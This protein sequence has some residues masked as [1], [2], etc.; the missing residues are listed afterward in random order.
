MGA[1]GVDA[2]WGVRSPESAG[3]IAVRPVRG[4]VLGRRR[5]GR[6]QD[7]AGKDLTGNFRIDAL[8]GGVDLRLSGIVFP[9]CNPHAA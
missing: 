8:L 6:Q 3:A 2:V 1:R 9:R 5:L 7:S 4:G